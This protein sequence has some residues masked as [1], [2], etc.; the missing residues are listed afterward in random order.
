MADLTLRGRRLE[1]VF[2]L[3]GDKEDDITYSVG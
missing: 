1:T 3:L 2:D